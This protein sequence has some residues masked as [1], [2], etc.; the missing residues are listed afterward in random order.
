MNPVTVTSHW[1]HPQPYFI[2]FDSITSKATDLWHD[3]N[4]GSMVTVSHAS[5]TSV[6]QGNFTALSVIE[7]AK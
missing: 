1:A 7:N 2:L 6:I 4:P 5:D 3:L